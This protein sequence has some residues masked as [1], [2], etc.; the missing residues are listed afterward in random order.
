M[1]KEND[2]ECKDI[3]GNE[4]YDGVCGLYQRMMSFK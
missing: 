4:G 2:T 1:I 3:K